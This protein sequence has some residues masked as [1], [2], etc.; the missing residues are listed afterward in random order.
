MRTFAIASA[1]IAPVGLIGGWTWAQ[2]RQPNSFDPIRQTVSALAA[3]GAQDRWIMTAGLLLLG[4]CHLATAA[5]LVE[6]GRTGRLLLALGGTA[7]MVVAALPQPNVGHIPA[8]TVGF[9]S[10]TL[11]PAFS[12]LPRRA[13]AVIA[14]LVLSAL[15][16]WLAVELRGGELL[17]LSERM[18]LAAQACWPLLIVLGVL[19]SH[20]RLSRSYGRV[21]HG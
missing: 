5:G 14:T 12:R 10:L 17:G 4:S 13:I 21:H 19:R 2:S 16:I 15:L 6:A 18:L 1:T 7:T 20:R 9:V 11:W 8:A 3:S